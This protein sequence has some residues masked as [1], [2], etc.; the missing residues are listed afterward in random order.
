MMTLAYLYPPGTH[1][2]EVPADFTGMSFGRWRLLDIER[3]A[4]AYRT[5]LGNVSSPLKDK[6]ISTPRDNYGWKSI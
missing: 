2:S 3:Q 4:E 1:L 6:P 5:T